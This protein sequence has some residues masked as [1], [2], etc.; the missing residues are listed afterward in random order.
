VPSASAPWSILPF[1]AGNFLGPLLL[2]RPFDTWGRR[3]TIAGTD[4]LSGVLLL[5]TAFLVHAEVLSAQSADRAV[6]R[7][8]LLGLRAP[9]RPT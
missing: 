2:G 4:I 7:D 5:V 8:L 9:R 6:A 1:A 3:A